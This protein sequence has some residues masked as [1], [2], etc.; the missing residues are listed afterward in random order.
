MDRLIA[1]FNELYP[2]IEVVAERGGLELYTRFDQE[3]DAGVPGGDLI[4]RSEVPWAEANA[5]RL[6]EIDGP[7]SNVYPAES[8]WAD[9]KAF[10]ALYSPQGTIVWNTNIFPDGFETWTDI[11]KY[12]NAGQ[13]GIRDTG[14]L[15]GATTQYYQ[16]L[17]R[18]FGFEFLEDLSALEP[19]IYPGAGPL[20][21]A[22]AAGEVG[23]G[24][25]LGPVF[26]LGLMSQGAPVDYIDPEGTGFAN[27]F[28]AAASATA[29]HP[30]ASRL[31]V[32]FMTSLEG[33]T[34]IVEGGYGASALTEVDGLDLN[35]FETYDPSLV[36]PEILEE[37]DAKFAELFR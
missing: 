36:T 4:I 30:N 2:G 28:I 16:F 8:V 25:S 18:N 13:Y 5:D 11:P 24:D 12:A 10:A 14:R 37:W 35:Q 26:A 31:F 7:N 21:Q 23:V 9:G 17:E 22:I 3:L 32:D 33:Q 19:K 6:L 15:T 29:P 34:A 20:A 1:S 27:V